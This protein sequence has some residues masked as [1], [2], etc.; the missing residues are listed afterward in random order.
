MIE[1]N[2]NVTL[3]DFGSATFVPEENGLEEQIECTELFGSAEYNAPEINKGYKYNAKR[4]DVFSCGVLL[5]VMMTALSPFRTSGEGDH[6]YCLLSKDN[7]NS[8][9]SNF[10]GLSPEFKDLFENLS[11][12][13][14]RKRMTIDEIFKHQ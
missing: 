11:N 7:K 10:P 8:F 1:S 9:W 3:A 13:E 5:F 14:S 6:Y 12:S 4:A 2:L